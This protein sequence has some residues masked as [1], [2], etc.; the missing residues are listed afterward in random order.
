MR[1]KANKE[2]NRTQAARYI[3]FLHCTIYIW[4]G[5][6]KSTAKQQMRCASFFI[7]DHSIGN[8][9]YERWYS[10]YSCNWLCMT[11]TTS[12]VLDLSVAVVVGFS[13]ALHLKLFDL[14]C[15]YI[16]CLLSRFGFFL[17][18]NEMEYFH[19]IRLVLLI[20]MMIGC[21]N[22][23]YLPTKHKQIKIWSFNLIM[24]Q[25]FRMGFSIFFVTWN[26]THEPILRLSISI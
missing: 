16:C 5:C 25:S 14:C 26:A 24:L 23:V 17:S 22:V 7:G 18:V 4:L 10:E 3:D 15:N 19:G 6:K 8:S 1:L 12:L 2:E 20:L 21:G 9:R 11:A 13:L